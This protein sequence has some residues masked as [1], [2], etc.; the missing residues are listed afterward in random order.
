MLQM[1]AN[2]G[3]N[4]KN[5]R[6]PSAIYKI[7]LFRRRKRKRR[8]DVLFRLAI[9]S[10]RSTFALFCENLNTKKERLRKLSREG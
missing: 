10:V 1:R 8:E 4:G 2:S 3:K 9:P 6:K 5:A 7:E